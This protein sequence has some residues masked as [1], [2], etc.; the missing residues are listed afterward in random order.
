MER[1][2]FHSHPTIYSTALRIT[3]LLYNDE[4]SHFQA[5]G[6]EREREMQKR[7]LNSHHPSTYISPLFCNFA[8]AK[9]SGDASN[10]GGSVDSLKA[11]AYIPLLRFK[12]RL[13]NKSKSI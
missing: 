12:H 8:R 9:F 6:R 3:R 2:S 13:K 10:R 7:C 4:I 5:R 11:D 1:P